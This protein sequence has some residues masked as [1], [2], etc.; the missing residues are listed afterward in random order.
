MSIFQSK[1]VSSRID[2]EILSKTVNK[3]PRRTTEGPDETAWTEGGYKREDAVS[4]SQDVKV[5]R[6]KSKSVNQAK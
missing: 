3:T 6:G 5:V 1:R 2:G 4:G